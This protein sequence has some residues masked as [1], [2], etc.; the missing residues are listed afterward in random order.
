M[1]LHGVLGRVGG[2]LF[3]PLGRTLLGRLPCHSPTIILLGRLPFWPWMGSQL[4]FGM[5]DVLG[6]GV[7][8]ELRLGIGR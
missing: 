7:Q 5:G 8:V 6:L 1:L 2:V 3:M 4:D